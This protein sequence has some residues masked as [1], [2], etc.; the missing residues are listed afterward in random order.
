MR[1]LHLS[2]GYPPAIGGSEILMRELSK[3]LVNGL[4]HRVTVVTTTAY[5]TAAFRIPGTPTMATGESVQ[6]GVTVRRHRASP[7]LAPRVERLQ[8]R[9]FRYRLPG[10][11]LLRTLYD[12]PLAPGMLV[13]ACRIEADLI[14]ATA[15]PLLHMHFAVAAARARR[16]PVVLF[17]ALHPEDRWGF[18]RG[19]IRAAIRRADV[20]CAYTEFERDHVI[21]LGVPPERVEIVAPGV[22]PSRFALADR[23]GA[24]AALGVGAAEPVVGFFGQV[25]GHKGVG[26]LIGAMEAVWDEHPDAWLVLAGART[27]HTAALQARADALPDA[28]RRRVRWALDVSDTAAAG[29][30][31][32]F[33]LFASPSGY[34]SFGLTFLEAW[35]AGLP[36]IGC[37]AGAVPALVED[38][39]DGLLV[40]PGDVGSLARAVRR[41]LDDAGLRARLAAAGEEKARRHTWDRSAGQLDAVYRRLSPG[42]DRPS[43]LL[44][45][46]RRGRLPVT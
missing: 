32:S 3:R 5:S 46:E 21:G 28:R 40:P 37:R 26:D 15:F 10:N 23:A 17:G 45:G 27:H 2:H 8:A 29:I 42:S 35:A 25:G 16:L 30:L 38:G 6:S 39:H 9:A 36:V 7:R 41:L 4:G 14:G 18:D 31:A 44:A 24:R 11:G 34:E 22:D 20:Y 1:V 19:V 33:D 13:D 43:T 12:G